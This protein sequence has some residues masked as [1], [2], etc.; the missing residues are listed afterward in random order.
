MAYLVDTDILIDFFRRNDSAADY[1]DSLGDWSVSVVSGLE[2]VAGAK[3]KAEVNEIDI[4]LGIYK[5]APVS[6][7]IGQLAYNLMKAH[8]KSNG[9][10]PCDA[11]IAATAIY[12]G[13]KLAT[14]N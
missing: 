6:S 2:L 14:K 11:L 9:I 4:V 3:N 7:E 1:L 13:L 8:A 12:G 5:A 10:D